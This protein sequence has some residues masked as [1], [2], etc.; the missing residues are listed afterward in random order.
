MAESGPIKKVSFGGATFNENDVKK[1]DVRFDNGKKIYCVFLNNGVKIEY[2][3]QPEEQNAQIN[4]RELTW[5]NSFTDDTRTDL[6]RIDGAMVTGS[7]NDDIISLNGCTNCK[8]DVSGD[9]NDDNVYI[10][11]DNFTNWGQNPRPSGRVS[12]HNTVIMDDNDTTR[13]GHGRTLAERHGRKI[14]GEGTHE[15]E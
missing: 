4:G 14:H 11:D 1:R 15:E 3:E 7:E 8:V 12:E 13:I 2:P 5:W 6:Y 9:D 10:G